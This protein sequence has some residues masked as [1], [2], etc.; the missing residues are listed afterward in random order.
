MILLLPGDQPFEN[1]T[2]KERTNSGYDI[3]PPLFLISADNLF[4]KM[5]K[6][7]V[8]TLPTILKILLFSCSI[9]S[10]LHELNAGQWSTSLPVVIQVSF[11]GSLLVAEGAKALYVTPHLHLSSCYL[12]LYIWVQ[13]FFSCLSAF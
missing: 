6:V 11:R 4:V 10:P 7:S 13:T 2:M 5:E 8:V 1:L 9:F 3:V 12:F